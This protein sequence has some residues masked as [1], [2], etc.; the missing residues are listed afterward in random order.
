MP[1]DFNSGIQITKTYGIWGW[2][3]PN[4]AAADQESL[5]DFHASKCNKLM[6]KILTGMPSYLLPTRK[7]VSLGLISGGINVLWS[8]K[9][10]RTSGSSV[11]MSCTTACAMASWVSSRPMTQKAVGRLYWWKGMRKD[12][13]NHIRNCSV[14]QKDKANTNQKSGGLLQPLQ[15]P[16]RGWESI[17]C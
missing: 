9:T 3:Y 1:R 17:R 16:D 14:C 10:V 8:S 5:A 2:A 13:F 15:N 4:L 7:A 6:C 11:C 12:V